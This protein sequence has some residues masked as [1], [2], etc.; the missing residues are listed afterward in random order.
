MPNMRLSVLMTSILYV[1][2]DL[3]EGTIE[4]KLS[5]PEEQDEVDESV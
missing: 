5:E 1:N 2:K 4:W 3:R